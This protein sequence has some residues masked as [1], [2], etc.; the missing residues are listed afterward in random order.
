MVYQWFLSKSM[1]IANGVILHRLWM[2]NSVL[3]QSNAHW[4]SPKHKFCLIYW[5]CILESF[6]RNGSI[7]ILFHYQLCIA[8]TP[9]WA[10]PEFETYIS[11]NQFVVILLVFLWLP[12]ILYSSLSHLFGFTIF[13]LFI[14]LRFY[15]CRHLCSQS[16]RNVDEATA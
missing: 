8:G 3:H 15:R 11:W 13:Y 7:S 12:S 5:I 10:M 1:N 6:F 9:M 14:S 4:Y 16:W 2:G